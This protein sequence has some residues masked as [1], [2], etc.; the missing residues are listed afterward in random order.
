MTSFGAAKKP[1]AGRVSYHLSAG[2]AL[3]FLRLD[4]QSAILEDKTTPSP[5]Y[6]QHALQRIPE[7]LPDFPLRADKLSPGGS[8]CTVTPVILR[9]LAT[10]AGANWQSEAILSLPR[11]DIAVLQDA[12]DRKS[13]V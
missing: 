7:G 6:R 11:E 3:A 13:V 1:C 10:V 4:Y 5:D 2:V 9:T 12:A 8:F